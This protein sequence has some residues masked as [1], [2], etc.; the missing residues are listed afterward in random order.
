MEILQQ[1]L[2][3]GD[4]GG[5]PIRQSLLESTTQ[6]LNR[7][8]PDNHPTVIEFV[9]TMRE[10]MLNFSQ[11]RLAKQ[12]RTEPSVIGA[13]EQET[14]DLQRYQRAMTEARGPLEQ[15]ARTAT[16]IPAEPLQIRPQDEVLVQYLRNARAELEQQR[17]ATS[18]PLYLDAQNEAALQ[19]MRNARANWEQQV[20]A[21]TNAALAARYAKN[22]I[23]QPEPTAQPLQVLVVVAS[24]ERPEKK[25]APDQRGLI[26]LG[27]Q[28]L[29]NRNFEDAVA[30][31]FGKP[32]TELQILLTQ[33]KIVDWCR[34]AGHPE[35]DV[36]IPEQEI[37]GGVL[38]VAV[39]EGPR[40]LPSRH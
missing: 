6:W 9:R 22:L 34:S 24:S 28:F 26:V 8:H 10:N 4:R 39:L 2:L 40:R 21:L 13:K 23:T 20:R 5:E 29:K 17:T 14:N 31:L 37:A 7:K 12:S 36:I 35:V 32:I 15:P 3:I 11:S 19:L 30:P 1:T 16:N 18:A 38:Q 27:P 33:K 25:S